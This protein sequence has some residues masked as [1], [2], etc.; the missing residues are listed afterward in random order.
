MNFAILLSCLV[1]VTMYVIVSTFGYL[2]VVG[3]PNEDILGRTNNILDID[4]WNSWFLISIGALIVSV[5]CCSPVGFLCSKDVFEGVY[6]GRKMTKF[7]NTKLTL[8]QLIV[9]Y[10]I[11]ISFPL[12]SDV[13]TV[14]GT[15]TNPLV[16]FVFPSIFY[17][18]MFPEDHFLKWLLAIAVMVL[19][20]LASLTGFGV[21]IYDKT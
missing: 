20:I 16:G 19:S 21:W 11:A 6:Y 5:F 10:L 18:K 3:T 14:I 2:I 1:V 12:I 8:I 15:T 17:L 9:C 7:E 4:E 13:I